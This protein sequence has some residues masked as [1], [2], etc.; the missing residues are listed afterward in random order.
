MKKIIDGRIWRVKKRDEE[1][2]CR[3]SHIGHLTSDI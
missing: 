2:E 3:I 1:L